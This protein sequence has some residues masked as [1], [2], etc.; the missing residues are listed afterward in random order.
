MN[1]IAKKKVLIL[2]ANPRDTDS[3]RLDQEVRSIKEGL[4]LATKRD[5]FMIDSE[6]AVR[7]RDI[8]RAILHFEPQIVHFSGHGIGLGGLAFENEEGHVQL[9]NTNAL[10]NLF[11]LFSH[12]I[13]CVL[14]NACYSE[15]QAEAISKHINFVIGMNHAIGDRAA[16]EFALGFY[17]ALYSACSIEKAYNFGCNAI[18]IAGINEHLIPILKQ[19]D[20]S[21]KAP[22]MLVNTKSNSRKISSPLSRKTTYE[23]VLTG[24]VD[25]IGKQKLEAIV[26]HLRKITGDTSLTLIEIEDGSI[27]L[28]LEGTEEGYHLLHTLLTSGE[29]EEILGIP[30]EGVNYKRFPQIKELNISDWF[31][32]NL[33]EVYE[34]SWNFIQDNI[35][36]VERSLFDTFF[37]NFLGIYIGFFKDKNKSVKL[38]CKSL[39]IE[40]KDYILSIRKIT[41]GSWRFQ[42][43][44]TIPGMAI[45]SNLKLILYKWDSTKSLRENKSS[46]L[47]ECTAGSKKYKLYIDVKLSKGD[48]VLW[49][50]EPIEEYSYYEVLCF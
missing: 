48:K 40:N 31:K 16:I 11:S 36:E 28:I 39:K 34:E 12:F 5:Q 50:V 2:T 27:K 17:D 33:V 18:Q 3:L 44:S 7:P 35:I 21:T 25:K 15:I 26:T 14:L 29:L 20:Y 38:L 43:E 9:I 22:E 42:L 13:E 47:G 49:I 19:K 8:R 45:L 24:S 37:D 4:K 1:R 10:A 23:F 32:D 30:V 6:W 41:E 46:I